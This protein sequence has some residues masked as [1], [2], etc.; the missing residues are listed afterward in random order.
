[1][2]AL[3]YLNTLNNDLVYDDRLIVVQNERV[4]LFILLF[5]SAGWLSWKARRRHPVVGFCVLGNAI[6][7]GATANIV[8][9]IGTIMGERLMY[10][11][12]AMLCLL[13]GYGAW[14]LQRSLNHNAAYL[15]PATVGIVFIFLTISRNTTWK[16]ELT[17]YETQVQTAPNSAKAHYNLGTALAKRG[18]GEGAVASYR[19]SLRLFPY[20]PEPLFNMGKGPYPQTYTRPR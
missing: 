4:I 15:A 17:F 5:I 6:L 18:D 3:V 1:M 10:A 9:P 11:P 16:D 13:V 19:T 7:F 14:L 8:I 12:S 20:Y 2:A